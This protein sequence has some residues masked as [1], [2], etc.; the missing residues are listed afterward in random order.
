SQA[1]IDQAVKDLEAAIK[2]LVDQVEGDKA[3]TSALVSTLEKAKAT[4][5]TGKT[6]ASIKALDKAIK[7]IE[8]VLANAA[9][10]QAEI[11]QAVKDLE[12]AIEGLVDK[13]DE[14]TDSNGLLLDKGL[15][16][17]G[18]PGGSEKQISKE[19]DKTPKKESKKD[20]KLPSSA[21]NIFNLFALGLIL[22][23]SGLL[24]IRKRKTN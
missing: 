9:S 17:D 24:L 5:T 7:N 19:T 20:K 8:A 11:D 6:V 3:D 14:K 15:N 12:A 13:S 1:E 4:D 2:G 22:I 16:G 10:T 23:I 21:T 18:K